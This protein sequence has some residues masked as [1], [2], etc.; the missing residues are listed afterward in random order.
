MNL[1]RYMVVVIVAG[2]LLCLVPKAN[3]TDSYW[4]RLELRGRAGAF[5][6]ASQTLRDLSDVWAGIGLDVVAPGLVGRGSSTVLSIDWFNRSWASGSNSVF[7]IILSETMTVA[8]SSSSDFS[9]YVGA[10]AGM[11]IGDVGGP[12]NNVFAGKVLV[13]VTL[14]DRLFAEASYLFTDRFKVFDDTAK[15]RGDGLTVMLGYKF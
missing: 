3:A 9:L 10:G 11:I 5:V 15:V 12:A 4:D 6:P 2:T 7:P 1:A 8:Q 13:G 14:T